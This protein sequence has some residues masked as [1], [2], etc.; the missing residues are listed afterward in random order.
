MKRHKYL[1]RYTTLKPY[2]EMMASSGV[3]VNK[4]VFLK[5]FNNISKRPI[6]NTMWHRV[7][8]GKNN[9]PNE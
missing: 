6:P 5:K 3:V 8:A 2:I 4:V 1:S 7:Y 9:L